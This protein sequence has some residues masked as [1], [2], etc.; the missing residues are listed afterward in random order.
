MGRNGKNVTT[1]WWLLGKQGHI[2]GIQV[3]QGSGVLKGYMYF[4]TLAEQYNEKLCESSD[5]GQTAFKR[6]GP[7]MKLCWKLYTFTIH[8]LLPNRSS[9]FAKAWHYVLL[10]VYGVTAWAGLC[11]LLRWFFEFSLSLLLCVGFAKNLLY[12]KNPSMLDEMHSFLSSLF[13][14]IKMC[15]EAQ[16]CTWS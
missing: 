6:R 14:L 5:V 15:R 8:S 10:Y 7:I 3:G 1:S 2:W 16:I 13:L 9:S 12:C 4:Y 11:L